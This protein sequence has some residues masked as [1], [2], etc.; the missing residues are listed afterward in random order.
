MTD[1]RTLAAAKAIA[2]ADHAKDWDAEADWAGPLLI[3]QERA[4]YLDLARA[5]FDVF[6]KVEG[7]HVTAMA[8]TEAAPPPPS[9]PAGA[10]ALGAAGANVQM[11]L[12]AALAAADAVEP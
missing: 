9:R 7:S 4:H 11:D 2:K 8:A 5:A 12:L 6:C 1:A 10:P 3:E